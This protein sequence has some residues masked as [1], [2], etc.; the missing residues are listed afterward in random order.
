MKA[1]IFHSDARIFN[2][3]RTMCN[4]SQ[5]TFEAVENF[6]LPLDLTTF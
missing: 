3:Y 6:D 5:R 2:R 4:T 1:L